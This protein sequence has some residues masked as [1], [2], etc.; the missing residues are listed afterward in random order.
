[1]P[2]GDLDVTQRTP[3][4]SAAMMKAA[5]SMWG[6]TI[7]SPARLPMSGPS[8]CGPPIESLAVMAM[9]DRALASLSKGESDGPGHPGNQRDHGRLVALPDDAQRPM[10][11]V[12][13]EVLCVGGAGLAHPQSVEAEQRGESGVVGVVALSREEE[14]AELPSVEPPAFA[15]VDLGPAGVL[16]WVRGDPAVDVGEAV[17]AADR[18]QPAIDGRGSQAALLH[19]APPQFD[20]G[21]L[22]PEDV[23]TPW[24][25]WP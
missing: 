11:P 18:G 15:W 6:W 2:G 24:D 8:G 14:S 1:M 10:T 12:E 5:R 7:P 4:S 16:C 17:E 23:E 9:Q 25:V 22:G 19:G 21:P 20:V 3:A 13:A